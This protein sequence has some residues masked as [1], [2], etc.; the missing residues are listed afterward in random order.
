MFLKNMKLKEIKKFIGADGADTISRKDGVITVRKGFYYQMGKTSEDFKNKVLKAF[1]D[2]KII[3]FGEH[4]AMFR[5][6][7]S[8]AK[9]SHWYVKFKL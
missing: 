1:P 6:G 8:V 3:D 2:A 7:A 4:Y 9:G 5:G